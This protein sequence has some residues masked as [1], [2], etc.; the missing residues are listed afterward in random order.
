MQPEW[1]HAATVQQAPRPPA[2]NATGVL[3]RNDITLEPPSLTLPVGGDLRGARPRSRRSP[4]TR[5]LKVAL[6][7]ADLITTACGLALATWIIVAAKALDAV[8]PSLLRTGLLSL[9]VWPVL[10]A[11][12]GLYQSRRV[13]LRLE[14]IRRIVNSTLAGMLMLAGISVLFGAPLSRGWLIAVAV[15]VTVLLVLEREV[16]RRLIHRSRSKG[17]MTRRVVVVGNNAEAAEIAAQL[18]EHPELGYE[19]VG[20]AAETAT[21]PVIDLRDGAEL[22]PYLGRPDEVL[23]VVRANGATGVIIATTGIDQEHANDLIRDLTREGLFAELTSA[24]RDISSNR[25]SVRPLG[26]YPILCV[27]PVAQLSWRRVAKRVFDIVVASVAIL[28]SLPILVI[29]AT[30]VRVTS[31]KGVLFR[32]ER[33]GKDGRPF[34][35]Y[36]LRTMVPDAEERLADLWGHNEAPVP[37]FKM[38]DDPRVTPIGRLLRASSIDELPQLFN[39]ILGDMSLVGPRPALPAEASQWDERLRERLRV[40]PGITGMWQVSGRYTASLET[41]A[42]LDLYYVDNWSLTTDLAI[43]ARTALVVVSRHGSA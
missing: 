2:T 25:I 40:Q 30:L 8:P 3:A 41:Y 24:M 43:L 13:A 38:T 29:A 7:V 10:Y 26:R 32:Q 31:G 4:F 14:E 34:K 19:V 23:D 42:R 33:I 16:V 36:K 28:L 12:Q 11:H 21:C 5:H 37:M 27:E 15:C 6:V 1:S 18:A 39:V 9:L 35:L 17:M 20:F 22:G